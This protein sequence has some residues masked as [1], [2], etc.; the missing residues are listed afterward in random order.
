MSSRAIT[1]RYRDPLDIVWLDAAR[2]LGMHVER[3]AAVYASWDGQGRLSVAESEA[4]DPDDSLAQIV[5]HE[6]CHALIA[7]PSGRSRPDWGLDNS[8]QADLIFEHACH[9]VQAS[10]AGRY[11]LREFFAVTTEWREYWD[12]LPS[13]PLAEN[14]ERP[15]PALPIARRALEAAERSP[16]REVLAE[17]LQRT[18][19]IAEI[20]R[21]QAEP[22]SLWRA[23]R[24]LH[25]SGF[26]AHSDAA[27]RCADC[28]WSRGVGRRLACRQAE[29]VGRSPRLSTIEPACERF[30]PRLSAES[31]KSC[32]ACC[33]EGFDR[34]ELR[35]K[36]TLGKLRPD[37]VSEDRFGPFLARPQGR[38][39]ALLGDGRDAAYRC[40]VYADRP[41]ACAK[42]EVGG[43]ACLIARRRTG[44]SQ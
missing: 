30:E 21:D 36:D 8:G 13:D 4:F 6:I 38:C 14:T 12:A 2:R 18:A 35:R 19:R 10:L 37:L 26:I 32:G 22:D 17:A 41:A 11:G 28:A 34:V 16:F 25:P 23:A 27:L 43:A 42:F 29:R 1:H 31:C 3:T 5:L 20:V 9:R 15:D 40:S 7:G 44:L 39:V 33:R 24:P